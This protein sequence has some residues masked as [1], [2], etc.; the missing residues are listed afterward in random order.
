MNGDIYSYSAPSQMKIFNESFFLFFALYDLDFVVTKSDNELAGDQIRIYEV[1]A[2]LKFLTQEA[3]NLIS[4]YHNKCTYSLRVCYGYIWKAV[5]ARN[6]NTEVQIV[7]NH[8][9][10]SV[11]CFSSYLYT[12]LSIKCKKN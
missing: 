3:N 7:W 5:L 8:T 4:F 10:S 12:N 9:Q 2:Y 1:E 6:K 11:R